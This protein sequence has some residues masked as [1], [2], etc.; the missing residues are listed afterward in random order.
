MPLGCLVD[1]AEDR[2]SA[3]FIGAIKQT[4]KGVGRAPRISEFRELIAAEEAAQ[5]V[6]FARRAALKAA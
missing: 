3:M 6:V 1:R 5:E 4:A 2:I